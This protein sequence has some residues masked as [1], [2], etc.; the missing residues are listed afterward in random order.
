[1]DDDF[2]AVSDENWAD[3]ADCM[4]E[5]EFYAQEAERLWRQ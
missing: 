5:D 2:G 3:P 4:T 1:M